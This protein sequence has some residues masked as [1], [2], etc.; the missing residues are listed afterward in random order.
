MVKNQKF[1]YFLIIFIFFLYPI[2]S[3]TTDLPDSIKKKIEY[4]TTDKEKIDKLLNIAW[5]N[6]YINTLYS[7][8]CANAALDMSK[9]LEDK[10]L[11]SQTLN[12]IGVL[13]LYNDDYQNANSYFI[14]A[15]DTAQ[16]Y[17]ILIQ[18]GYSYNNLTFLNNKIGNLD[19]A[20]NYIQKAKKIMESLNDEN[21]IA[22]VYIRYSDYFIEKKMWD[23]VLYYALETVKLRERNKAIKQMSRALLNVG[24]AYEGLGNQQKALEIY[25]SIKDDI[26]E[27]GRIEYYIANSYLGLGNFDEAIKLANI[28]LTKSKSVGQKKQIVNAYKLLYKIYKEMKLYDKAL[29]Y[30]E[31]MD[32]YND[33]LM[34][35]TKN[36]EL[37]ITNFHLTIKDHEKEFEILK[38]ENVIKDYLLLIS[39]VFFMILAVVIFFLYKSVQK[40]NETNNLLKL[41]NNEILE[42]S[43][44]LVELNATKDKFFS[45]I[46]HDL[47][48]PIGSFKLLTEMLT[49]HFDTMNKKEQREFITTINQSSKQ[50]NDLLENLLEWSRI[51]QSKISFNPDYIELNTIA[52]INMQ[53]VNAAASFKEINVFNE[54][55]KETFVYA[56]FNMISTVFRNLLTNAIKYTYKKGYV[57]IKYQNFN[58]FFGLI[59]I[60]DNGK[61]M[62]EE[63]LKN[64]FKI[65]NK[66]I[67][68][69]TN[70]E[71]GTGIGLILCKEFV[72]KNEG[73]IWVESIP[74]NGSKFNF[75]LLKSNQNS[76]YSQQ[77][78][79]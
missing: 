39:I 2:N 48:N 43:E 27:L 72:E 45:I 59:T 66:H 32:L 65:E 19:A 63:I 69:G 34:Y 5:N 37:D 74:G 60:E 4:L 62:N 24:A 64:I 13:F 11:I 42:Q 44:K 75:T 68:K 47:R 78:I 70:Q 1:I 9:E 50:V 29:E 67:E 7:M 55:P 35:E 77:I 56:D 8:V 23:S 53:L 21:G 33:S 76:N 22:Y 14:Q 73:T 10:E 71:K 54:I 51:Q 41:K 12:Y 15:L 40:N 79:D 46:A 25:F 36:K 61:G 52:D 38:K 20:H 28:S 30:K 49:D 57:K 26:D 17:N 16:K 3:F 18:E 31:S 58:D 6:R